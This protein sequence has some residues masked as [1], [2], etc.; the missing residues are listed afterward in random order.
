MSHFFDNFSVEIP[1]KSLWKHFHGFSTGFSDPRKIRVFCMEIFIPRYRERGKWKT[2]PWHL[3]IRPDLLKSVWPTQLGLVEMLKRIAV[4]N[5][6]KQFNERHQDRTS[7]DP[8]KNCPGVPAYRPSF[9]CC[10][11]VLRWWYSGF[12][13]FVPTVPR[14]SSR[15]LVA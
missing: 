2:L 4:E 7:R 10:F 5:C 9:C 3:L 14:A 15:Y 13:I 1:W 11:V 6:G 12:L 8:G